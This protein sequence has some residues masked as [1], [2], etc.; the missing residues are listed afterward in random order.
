MSVDLPTFGRPA[1]HAKP[2]LNSAAGPAGPACG[3]TD[4]GRADRGEADGAVRRDGVPTQR[5]SPTGA[6][7]P[8]PAG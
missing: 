1:K 5:F 7:D 8:N 2:D 3:R 4:G 6:P